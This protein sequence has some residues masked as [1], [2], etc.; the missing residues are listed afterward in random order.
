M[1]YQEFDKLRH[2]SWRLDPP[3]SHV[4]PVYLTSDIRVIV[5]EGGN[6]CLKAL[7]FLVRGAGLRKLNGSAVEGEV[8]I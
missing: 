1:V 7:E 2:F 5:F 3:S 6:V 8:E 4:W